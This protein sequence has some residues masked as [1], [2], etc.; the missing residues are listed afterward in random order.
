MGLVK[1]SSTTFAKIRVLGVGGGG[2]NAVNSMIDSNQIEGVEFIAVNTDAQALLTSKAETKMQIGNNFTRGLGAGA[3]PE[4]GRTAAEESSEKLKDMLFDSDMVFITAGMGGGTGTGAAPIIAQIAKEAGALTVAVV[5]KPFMFEGVRRM[6]TAEE[7]I[8]ILKDCVD[9]LIVIPNQRLLE[10]VDKKMTL[11]D[12]FRLADNVLGQGVKGISDLIT[13][14]GMINVDFADVKTIMQDS[15][16]ALMGIGEATGTDRAVTAARMAISSPLLEVSVEGAK[17]LLYNITGGQNITMT[18]ISDASSIIA[19]AADP[20]AN[21]I[22][23]ANINDEMGDKIKISVIA[24]GFDQADLP[25]G[26]ARRQMF[27]AFSRTSHKKFSEPDENGDKID[28]APSG[29]TQPITKSQLS[30]QDGAEKTD[31]SLASSF[32]KIS[33]VQQAVSGEPEQDITVEDDNSLK[34]D[35]EVPA[36]MRNK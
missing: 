6:Q 23:G 16:T 11:I 32:I 10:V 20:D 13:V 26:M 15:G 21:I 14:P 5:T 8:E 24:T 12:A 35:F 7:G 19:N 27:G 31:A 4:V 36:F 33:G 29:F 17:G 1:P 28:R 22:F 2:G 30:E 18:E 25:P 3:D 9:T 34:D